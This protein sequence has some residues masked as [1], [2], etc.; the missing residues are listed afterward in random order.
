[1]Q[2]FVRE[3]Y[4]ELY[5]D[6]VGSLSQKKIGAVIGTAG[7]GKSTFSLYFL[8]R[9][10]GD[11]GPDNDRSFY[12]QVE[13]TKVCFFRHTGGNKYSTSMRSGVA[14]DPKFPLFIDMTEDALPFLHL[15]VAILFPCFQVGQFEKYCRD[16]WYKVMPTW[17]FDELTT[18]T[19]TSNFWAN[20]NL[21]Q[22][23]DMENVGVA[24]GMYGGS[25]RSV[26]YCA[27]ELKAGNL[28]TNMIDLEIDSKGSLIANRFLTDG[29]GGPDSM[30]EV[31]IHI[32]PRLQD[33]ITLYDGKD[34]LLNYCFASPYVFRR[35]KELH[36]E[37]IVTRARLK[38]NN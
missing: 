21:A 26:I 3:C 29:F 38:Y 23:D 18:Y 16:G 35:I 10:L 33:G 1:M 30:S 17:K 22:A 11:V 36:S 25:L 4:E 13:T 5:D 20:H 28:G 15:G 34:V 32:N 9:Y 12:Y 7:I 14:L 8:H 19:E 24:Y 2:V 31:L 37:I 6:I 27:L